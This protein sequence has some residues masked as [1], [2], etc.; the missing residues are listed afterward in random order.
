MRVVFLGGAGRSGS[1]LLERLLGELPGVC[2]LGEVTQLWDRI[3]RADT[4]CGCGAPVAA[5]DFWR[6]VGDKAFGGWSAVDRERIP[7]L[8]RAVARTRHVPRFLTGHSRARRHDALAEYAEYYA[9]V[10]TAAAAV[11]GCEVIVDAS[12]N[13]GLA[14]SLR[15]APDLTLRLVHLVRD[16][17]AVAHSWTRHVPSGERAGPTTMRRVAPRRASLQ[18]LADNG[19]MS[20][21]AAFDRVQRLRYEDLTADPRR[22]VREIAAFAGLHPTDADLAFLDGDR[23]QFSARHGVAGNPMRFHTGEVPLRRDDAWR[24]ALPRRQRALVSAVCAPL[25]PAYGYPLTG[26]RADPHDPPGGADP[27][28]DAAAA[29]PAPARPSPVDE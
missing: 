11:S 22:A 25:L 14:Y 3:D 10:Y 9:R 16:P 4:R 26:G 7:T 2:A 20:L 15:Y 29:P 23:A 13:P 5:C 1:T 12:K 18:W 27:G 17:R 21:L 24:H 19:A 28:S 6:A 8:Q